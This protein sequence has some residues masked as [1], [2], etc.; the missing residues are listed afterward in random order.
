MATK[1]AIHGDLFTA[2]DDMANVT[3]L[4]VEPSA[5]DLA[6]D[7]MPEEERDYF[8]M[9]RLQKL[10]REH[11]KRDHVAKVRASA[12]AELSTLATVG[13]KLTVMGA[14]HVYASHKPG[15]APKLYAGT[16]H[17]PLEVLTMGHGVARVT[18][19][20]VAT[21]MT[22]R[23]Q[24]TVVERRGELFES[25]DAET[26][27]AKV[28][29]L[30]REDIHDTYGNSLIVE[31]GKP[32]RKKWDRKQS[33]MQRHDSDVS[34]AIARHASIQ[35]M[36]TAR[37]RIEALLA[38]NKPVPNSLWRAGLGRTLTVVEMNATKRQR[39]GADLSNNGSH[40]AYAGKESAMA[41]MLNSLERK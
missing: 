22:V 24:D 20:M 15:Y 25:A 16:P 36:A 19:T 26:L 37:E 11:A 33:R 23:G 32:S 17:A 1:I 30:A 41:R 40:G 21:R 18:H 29:D 12:P 27:L 3:W 7:V 6:L 34:K 5:D 39:A 28:I 35:A 2:P 9:R 31:T 13:H 8:N 14:S 38:E 4:D 10:E